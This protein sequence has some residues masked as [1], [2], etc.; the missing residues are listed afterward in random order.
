MVTH[1]GNECQI[2]SGLEKFCQVKSILKIFFFRL[3]PD[4]VRSIVTSPHREP[5][6]T[7]LTD[8]IDDLVLHLFGRSDRNIAGGKAPPVSGWMKI[9]LVRRVGV[10]SA[11]EWLVAY[12]ISSLQIIIIRVNIS[13]MK[14][15]DI[16]LPRRSRSNKNFKFK[17]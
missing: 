12:L 13:Q 11:A 3:I 2:I 10:G 6:I 7:T 1:D 15:A 16:G 5:D 17:K 9:C 4:I 8:F 14:H